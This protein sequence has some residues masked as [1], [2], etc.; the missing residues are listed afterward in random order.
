MRKIKYFIVLLFCIFVLSS[1]KKPTENDDNPVMATKLSEIFKNKERK[2]Y[3]LKPISIDESLDY[4]ISN[5][6]SYNISFESIKNYN[7]SKFKMCLNYKGDINEME[8]LGNFSSLNLI[9][10]Q[11]MLITYHTS[12]D[13]LDN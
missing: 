4:K 10:N 13:I 6:I 11:L 2:D 5:D 12:S 7:I 1:C 8:L 3:T 9:N